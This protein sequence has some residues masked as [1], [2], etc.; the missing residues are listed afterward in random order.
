MN[1]LQPKMASTEIYSEDIHSVCVHSV[2]HWQRSNLNSMSQG[3]TLL[4]PAPE[5]SSVSI[6]YQP[7]IGPR[8]LSSS[9]SSPP[10]SSSR[11]VSPWDVGRPRSASDTP[12]DAD[13]YPT[14]Q[15]ILPKQ[16]LHPTYDSCSISRLICTR[17][18][19]SKYWH[20]SSSQSEC[21]VFWACLSFLLKDYC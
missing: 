7:V 5:I 8:S 2:P 16:L 19:V 10:L 13:K 11:S 15:N 20:N 18:P 14:E 12:T 4:L 9:F 6:S 21:L 3:S 1:M 17:I